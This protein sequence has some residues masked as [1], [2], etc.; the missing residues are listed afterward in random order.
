MRRAWLA[1]FL[2]ACGTTGPGS[3]APSLTATVSPT[4]IAA[5]N[6]VEVTVTT[7][8]FNLVDPA[9]N[10]QPAAGEGHFH[11]YI[12]TKPDYLVADFVSPAAVRI[13][14]DTPAGS[15]MLTVALA[16]NDHTLVS[17]SVS[18]ILPIT[19]TP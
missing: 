13:P 17:P 10:P 12:E 7:M 1:C 8:N 9:A 19:V 2:V 6:F 18:Q 3:S 5:G 16:N 15:H 14:A 4:T 11:V